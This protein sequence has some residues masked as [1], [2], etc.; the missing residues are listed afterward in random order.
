MQTSRLSSLL[1]AVLGIAGVLL[2]TAS[3]A[4]QVNLGNLPPNTA[5]GRLGSSVSGP[6]QAIPFVTL[7]ASIP[8]GGATV[9]GDMVLWNS[10]SGFVFKDSGIAVSGSGSISLATGKTITDTSLIGANL[11]LGSTAGGFNPYTGASCASNYITAIS[12][13]GT[14]TCSAKA[15]TNSTVASP[16]APNSTSVFTMQGLA[17]AITPAISGKIFVTISGTIITTQTAAGNGVQ[18]QLSHGTGTAPTSNAALTG[19]QD[20]TVQQYLIPATVTAADV[21]VPFSISVVLTGLTVGTAYW[22]DLAGKAISATGTGFA[23]VNIAVSE[24]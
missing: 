14:V 13:A 21:Q 15:A 7:L 5:V 12:A 23:N 1:A 19:T 8:S 4:Q 22:I 20:G 2:G 18:F 16:S 11:L 10:T 9:V 24:I 17:G 3:H 6:A